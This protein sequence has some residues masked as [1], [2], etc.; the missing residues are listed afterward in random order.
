MYRCESWTIKKAEPHRTDA[1]ELWCWGRLLRV[2]WTAGRSKQSIL[3][4]I[5]PK[6]S[7]EGLMLKLKLLYFGHLMQRVDSLKKKPSCWEGMRAGGE[8]EDKRW[9]GWMALPTQYTWVWVNSGSWWWTGRPGTCNS[10]G[11]KESDTTERLNWTGMK[12]K[13][14]A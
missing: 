2:P 3:K 4:E 5:R 7:L 11:G 10:W 1:F 12:T 6:C 13:A 9:D 14:L 8:G